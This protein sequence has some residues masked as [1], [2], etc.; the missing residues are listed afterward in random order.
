M[1]GLTGSDPVSLFWSM[2]YDDTCARAEVY[3]DTRRKAQGE[4]NPFAA[5]A[6]RG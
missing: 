2:Q 1:I 3:D 5:L 6:G 4:Q